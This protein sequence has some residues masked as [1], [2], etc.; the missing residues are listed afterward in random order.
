M[1]KLCIGLLLLIF[2]A[3][4][5]NESID[6][7]IVSGTNVD[8][9]TI[10]TPPTPYQVYDAD[11]N[12]YDVDT[13]GTQIWM[14]EN[15]KTTTYNGGAPIR[16]ID[17]P[18]VFG[19]YTSAGC[20]YVDYDENNF[21]EFGLLYN[22]YA[23]TDDICPDSFRIPT[24]DDWIKL[25]TY[26]GVHIDSLYIEP[27]FR[28]AGA[29]SS[30]AGEGWSIGKLTSHYEYQYTN[31]NAIPAGRIMGGIGSYVNSPQLATFWTITMFNE[32]VSYI[33]ELRYN[34]SGIGRY[35]SN[36][37]EGHSLRCVKDYE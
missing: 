10:V 36:K 14:A 32:E 11:G 5:K 20:A 4:E 16:V 25:E 18:R 1:K 30:L 22:Y 26:L 9:T 7:E 35:W 3:C 15:L 27:G 23:L 33:R 2:T 13:I 24:E 8:D 6:K 19:R 28:G 29:G 37:T 21:S 12:G 34:E 17:T 31:F